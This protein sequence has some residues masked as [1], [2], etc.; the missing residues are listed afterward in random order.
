MLVSK[1]ENKPIYFPPYWKM[2][3]IMYT[4]VFA[5]IETMHPYKLQNVYE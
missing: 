2:Y 5:G 4:M 3:G 1:P